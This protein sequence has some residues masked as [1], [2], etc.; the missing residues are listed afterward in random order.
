MIASIYLHQGISSSFIQAAVP[1]QQHVACLIIRFTL[2]YPMIHDR[3]NPPP[4]TPPRWF[5][6]AK[7]ECCSE[8]HPCHPCPVQTKRINFDVA[9][10]YLFLA[11]SAVKK[12]KVMICIIQQYRWRRKIDY[13]QP[14]PFG[15]REEIEEDE[16]ET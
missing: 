11:T 7:A 14:A 2:K 13:I 10:W 12:K 1:D 15:I 4:P 6:R 8:A 3:S 5:S 9:T 16:E